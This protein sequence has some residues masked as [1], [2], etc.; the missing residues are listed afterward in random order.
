MSAKT[1]VRKSQTLDDKLQTAEKRAVALF[2]D[3]LQCSKMDL[4]I[5]TL[6]GDSLVNEDCMRRNFSALVEQTMSTLLGTTELSNDERIRLEHLI[7]IHLELISA[8]KIRNRSLSPY[9]ETVLNLRSGIKQSVYKPKWL[10]SQEYQDVIS[11]SV[12]YLDS[13]S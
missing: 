9:Q 13:F 8:I 10:H 5:I 2:N 6:S 3:A 11:K 12:M 1:I 7:G 4:L